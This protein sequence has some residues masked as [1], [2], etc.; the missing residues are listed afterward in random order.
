MSV[1]TYNGTIPNPPN[2]PASDVLTMQTNA[3]SIQGLIKVD[4][5]D[6]NTM[7]G[8]WHNQMTLPAN[9]VP[10]IDV[11]TMRYLQSVLFT[12]KAVPNPVVN[13]NQLFYYPAGATA[14]QSSSQYYNSAANGNAVQGSAIL[15]GGIIL[16]WGTYNIIANSV[17]TMVTFAN[18]ANAQPFPNGIF[19]ISV[20]C[21]AFAVPNDIL[22][23]A[24]SPAA[25]GF[26]GQRIGN[27]A[28]QASY[29]FIAIGN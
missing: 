22:C 6:F 16:K 3:T 24:T 14:A 29:S 11:P 5:V 23:T 15:L 10:N 26:L 27:P 25:G 1:F 7:G 2:D 17:S 4:H 20:S 12:N 19:A 13:L 18:L 21:T 8:G 9:N 28:T